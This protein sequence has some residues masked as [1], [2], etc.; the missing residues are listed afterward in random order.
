MEVF[1]NFC[2]LKKELKRLLAKIQQS[3]KKIEIKNER[4]KIEILELK[5]E[6]FLCQS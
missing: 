4:S 6:V 5:F 1:F 2:I 3:E